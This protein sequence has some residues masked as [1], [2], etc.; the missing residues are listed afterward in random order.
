LRN[1]HSF[2]SLSSL[3]EQPVKHFGTKNNKRTKMHRFVETLS[4]R[5]LPMEFF[6]HI[7]QRDEQNISLPFQL[8]STSMG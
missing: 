3:Q 7:P 6:K 8:G 4:L 5:Q 2:L 1:E